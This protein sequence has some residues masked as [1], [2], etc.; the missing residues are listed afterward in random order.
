MQAFQFKVAASPK[1]AVAY[2][3]S[4]AFI[5]GGTNLIDLMKLEVVT[6]RRLSILDRYLFA[7]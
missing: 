1:E 6:P 2:G 3:A 5:A 4:G 7:E